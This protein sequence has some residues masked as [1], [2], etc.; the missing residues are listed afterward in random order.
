MGA[1]APEIPSCRTQ[2][3]VLSIPT[4]AMGYP[5]RLRER[6]DHIHLEMGEGEGPKQQG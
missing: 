3:C 4:E 1:R 5:S 6:I 2:I